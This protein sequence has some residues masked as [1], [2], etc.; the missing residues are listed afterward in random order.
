MEV[1]SLAKIWAQPSIQ[2]AVGPKQNTG[3]PDNM[4]ASQ[5]YYALQ[6]HYKVGMMH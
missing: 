5:Y 3:I 4:L 1:N 2:T 6:K